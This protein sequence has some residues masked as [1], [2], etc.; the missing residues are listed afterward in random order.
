[1]KV[2][3]QE[4]VLSLLTKAQLK[5]I[6]G[7]K[8]SSGHFSVGNGEC[9]G[10]ERACIIGCMPGNFNPIQSCTIPS[11]VRPPFLPV[12]TVVTLSQNDDEKPP[13]PCSAVSAEKGEEN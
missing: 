1:M 13:F 11:A 9:A 6:L 12:C 5:S 4:D 3:K 10:C 7:G 8:M 2:K